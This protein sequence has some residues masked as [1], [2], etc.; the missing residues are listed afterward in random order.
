MEWRRG[1]NSER[2]KRKKKK[3]K[4]EGG[5][6]GISS[7]ALL[8]GGRAQTSGLGKGERT[9]SCQE[10]IVK[11]VP[12]RRSRDSFFLSFFFS[13]A[14][15]SLKEAVIVQLTKQGVQSKGSLL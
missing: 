15:L 10:R 14:L 6:E 5:E 12:L 4:Q 1:L 9:W 13:F 11:D 7:R 8:M 3:K 2:N